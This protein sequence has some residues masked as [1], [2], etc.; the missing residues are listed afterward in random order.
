MYLVVETMFSALGTCVQVEEYEMDAY[1]T[2]IA[3]GAASVVS[4]SPSVRQRTTV[5]VVSP[6]SGGLWQ[7]RLDDVIR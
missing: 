5:A 6:L 4:V 2:I 3:S 7:S 1:F